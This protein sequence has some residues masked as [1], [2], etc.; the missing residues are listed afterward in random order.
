LT[1]RVT[2]N[3]GGVVTSVAVNVSVN[4][5]EAKLY[6]IHV[7]HLNT[8]RLVADDQQRTVWRWDQQEPFGV[9]VPEENPSG[10][11]IFELPLRLPG[12]YYDRETNLHYNYFRDYNP[13]LGG[14]VEGDPIGLRG[15]INTYVYVGGNPLL[16]TDPSGLKA[17]QCRKPLD[18]LTDKFGSA[19]A[20]FAYKYG[21]HMYHQYS[22]V[23]DANGQVTCGGQDYAG[24]PL[25]GPGTPSKDKYDQ[26]R[27]V[28][29]VDNQCFDD[30]LKKEWA[31]SRPK[32]GIPFGTDCQEYDDDVNSRCRKECGLK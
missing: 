3:L 4:A 32:Y 5:A 2:D 29:T 8:P 27:C 31:K 17:Y 14:Y 19:A 1:A 11:G 6:Y 26:Q 22:C 25:R 10:L 13:S 7:D 21:S 12:Q 9:N 16:W 28:P 15:G 23:V 18:A 30:C 20:E 24:N